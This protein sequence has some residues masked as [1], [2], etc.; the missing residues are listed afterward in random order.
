[1]KNPIQKRVLG[2]KRARKNIHRDETRERDSDKKMRN[3]TS[4]R[5]FSFSSSSASKSFIFSLSLWRNR[6]SLDGYIC[7]RD[8]DVRVFVPLF[9]SLKKGIFCLRCLG[10]IDVVFRVL[11]EVGLFYENTFVFS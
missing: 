7:V 2:T 8:L 1:M 5:I 11:V 6:R 3:P 4:T 9:S 10:F